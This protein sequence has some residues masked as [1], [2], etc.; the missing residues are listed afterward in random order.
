MQLLVH[1]MVVSVLAVVVA[2][3]TLFPRGGIAHAGTVDPMV[4]SDNDGCTAAEEL[5]A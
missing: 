5:G 4:D 3:A 2:W 1:L